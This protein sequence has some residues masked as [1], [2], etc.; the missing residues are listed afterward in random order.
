MIVK[1]EINGRVEHFEIPPYLQMD[2]EREIEIYTSQEGIVNY[3]TLRRW[4]RRKD[5][6]LV[7]VDV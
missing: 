1:T 5:V 2:Y 4:A 3:A 6:I 7:P